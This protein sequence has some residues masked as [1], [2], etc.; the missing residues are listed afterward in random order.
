VRHSLLLAWRYLAYHRVRTALLVACL[1]LVFVL[2]VA[3]RLLVD[4]YSESMAARAAATPLVAGAKGS[5]FDLVLSALYF[6][7]RVPNP[8]TM[9]EIEQLRRSGLARAIPLH[10]GQQAQ[11][12]PVVG[13]TPDYFAF[14][15]LRAVRGTA[16]LRLGDATLGAAVARD[17]GLGPGDTLLSDRG[18][19]YDLTLAYPLLMHVV[20]VFAE[21]GTPD[22]E[23]VFVDVKTAWVIEGIG[24]GHGA[25]TAQ[26]TDT[27]LKRAKDNVVLNA[28]VVEH[29]EITPEN[30]ASF[31]FHGDPE[32]FPITAVLVLPVDDRAATK[33]K[34]RFRVSKTAQLLVPADVVAEI[35]G[36]VFRLKVY[37]DANVAL[38]TLAT[39]LFL[40]LV[41]LLSLRLRRREME[42]LKKIGCARRTVAVL[43][44]TELLLVIGAGLALA[45][46]GGAAVALALGA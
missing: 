16:P 18:S 46:A 3:V 25:A 44:G 12:R 37:F 39:M 20:G 40:V 42:T 11:G 9:A 7:G 22:D 32:T 35:L 1:A 43:M 34:G 14:R 28:S 29:N 38:V 41:V 5:R 8:C 4:S 21:T 24:H 23:A 2:P 19:L 17:L 33:L 15:G 27:V 10:C 6:R 31:H 26:G 36:F 45:A 13:T 30:V